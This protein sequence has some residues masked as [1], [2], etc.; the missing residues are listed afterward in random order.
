MMIKIFIPIF[1]CTY[2]VFSIA[3][4]SE[5][6]R[7]LASPDLLHAQSEKVNAQKNES[8]S[9][10]LTPSTDIQVAS[11]VVGV[12]KSV[13]VKR[14]DRVKKN[15]ILV[16]LHAEVER[17]TLN[18]NKAQA[19]YGKRTIKRNNDLYKRKLISEQERDEIIINNQVYSYEMAQ[20]KELLKQKTIRSPLNGVVVNTFLD[21]GEYV[22]EEPIMQIVALD[23]L[24]VEVVLPASRFGSIQKGDIATVTLDSPLNSSH[25]AKVIIID[26][27]LDAASATFGVRLELSNPDYALPAGLKCQVSL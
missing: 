11:P 8:D 19:D 15:Q 7:L 20:T 18:L 2:S 6:E 13:K 17:S 3:E 10:L 16:Q 23:P 4:M 26:P 22:G 21:Q 1:L 25:Q 27:V 9:C 14:G 12:I 5:A 24:Y